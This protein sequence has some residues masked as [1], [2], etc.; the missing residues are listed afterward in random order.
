MKELQMKL[1]RNITI[2]GVI[3]LHLRRSR[4]SLKFHLLRRNPRTRHL[5]IFVTLIVHIRRRLTLKAIEEN[6]NKN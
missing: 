2:Y 4:W 5:L 6:T 1:R 3:S